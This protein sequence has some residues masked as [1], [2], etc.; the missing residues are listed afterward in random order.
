LASCLRKLTW[1]KKDFETRNVTEKFGVANVESFQ[2][3]GKKNCHHNAK[4]FARFSCWIQCPVKVY[5][6]SVTK[7]W[8]VCIH[9]NI[10]KKFRRKVI[11]YMQT[12]YIDRS[13]WQ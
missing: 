1:H 12:W 2:L 7:N 11:N 13:S 4:T 9:S 5:Q 10:H 6:L 8:S 3:W